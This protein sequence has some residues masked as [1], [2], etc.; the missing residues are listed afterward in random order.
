MND[1]ESRIRDAFRGHEAD[2][3]Q[4][5]ASD[6]RSVAD[7]TRRR[8]ILN[9]AGAGIVGLA[10]VVALSAELGGLVRADR[11]PADQDVQPMPT[12]P[13]ALAYR[14]AP[15]DTG[16]YVANMDGSDAVAITDGLVADGCRLGDGWQSPSWSPDGRY[17]AVGNSGRCVVVITYPQGDVVANIA[18]PGATIGW[19][20]DASRF[21]VWDDRGTEPSCTEG[22]VGTST[23]GIYGID[24]T[25]L[26]QIEL[27]I[28]GGDPL[29]WTPD[30]SA[31]DVG[32]LEVPVDG[33]TPRHIPFVQAFR[34][35]AG[36]IWEAA[37]A[38]SPDGSQVAYGTR[39][40]LVVARSD[41]SEPREVLGD[42]AYSAAWSPNGELLAVASDLRG[43]QLAPNQL[44]V[45]DPST[46]SDTLV[47][48]SAPGTWL[49]A[50]GFSPDGDRVLFGEEAP[51][52]ADVGS[53]W[54]VGLDGSDAREIVAGTSQ[55]VV[56]PT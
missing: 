8:Q 46:G 40:G 4:F 1:L 55:A 48:E 34:S 52:G 37:F 44:R 19:S 29:V 25:R 2:A 5:D 41:W 13:G 12:A 30:G 47:F 56:R 28:C 17:L 18:V 22:G 36:A 7:R 53:L 24:G 14:L 15:T 3:P 35:T 27:P 32:D 26:R 9:V 11:V 10:V 50:I 16:I 49:N 38:Y 23:I 51:G 45:V 6:A 54:S 39:H 31:L 42:A 21:A 20:P 33:G 43:G